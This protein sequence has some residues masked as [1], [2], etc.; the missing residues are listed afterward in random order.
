MPISQPPNNCTRCWGF[1]RES[2][3]RKNG[4]LC[5]TCKLITES[6]DDDEISDG[7]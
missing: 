6:M 5:D 3:L 4:G 1:F 2:L 7:K